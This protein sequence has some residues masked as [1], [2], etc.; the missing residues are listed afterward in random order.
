MC[1][2][3]VYLDPRSVERVRDWADG[4]ATRDMS[5]LPGLADGS[6][7]SYQ[8][9]VEARGYRIYYADV[10]TT[11]VAPTGM[12]VVR[13]LVP[14]LVPNFAAAFPFHGHGRLRMAAVDL[15]WRAE[16]LAEDEINLFPIAHA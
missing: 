8:E 4:P 5:E 15:G 11:D 3:Q 7:R 12:R 6:M 1:Q 9:A 16:P 10:T 2:V 13:V 14:G